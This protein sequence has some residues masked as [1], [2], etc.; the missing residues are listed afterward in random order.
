[1]ELNLIDKS[2]NR[3]KFEIIGE[4]HTLC[5][6]IRRELWNDKDVEVAGYNIEHSLVG[7][8]VFIVESKKDAKS[9]LIDAVERLKKRNKE[10]KDK[11]KVAVK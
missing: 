11:F 8:P 5:N 1:M 7:N 6:A 10:F 3:L 9:A 2:K 4:G